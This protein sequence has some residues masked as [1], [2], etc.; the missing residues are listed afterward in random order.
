MTK[1]LDNWC[2]IKK[3]IS[4]KDDIIFLKKKDIRWCCVWENLW[5]EQNWKWDN[6]LRPVLVLKVLNKHS[7]IWIP[8]SSQNHEWSFFCDFIFTDEKW[9]KE[10][11][12]ALLNQIKIFS[13]KRLE[14]I[15]WKMSSEDFN[16]IKKKLWKLLWII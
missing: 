4:C 8:L 15:A 7:F 3:I 11:K 10:I 13:N 6:F 5:Y 14:D 9:E 16:K 1:K 12:T 2:K